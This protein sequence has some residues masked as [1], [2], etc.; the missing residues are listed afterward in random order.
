MAKLIEIHPVGE[1]TTVMINADRILFV[2]DGAGTP[3]VVMI[4]GGDGDLSYPIKETA[5]EV[6]A[7]VNGG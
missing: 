7:L 5:A 6:A 1:T 2:H 4:A 3:T